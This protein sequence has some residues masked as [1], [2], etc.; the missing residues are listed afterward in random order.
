MQNA[1]KNMKDSL[2]RNPMTQVVVLI[3]IAI[4]AWWLSAHPLSSDES[5]TYHHR[6]WSSAYFIVSLLGGI[7][8]LI[9]S[10]YWGGRKSLLGRAL[11]AFSVGLLLQTFGQLAYN[12]YIIILKTEAPY[13][14]LGDVGYFGSVLAY[15]YGV[16]LLGHV[17]GIKFSFKS[18]RNQ[19][20]AVA[21][22]LLMLVSTWLI[23][24]KGYE[25]DWSN[26]MRI[27]LDFGYPLGQA[28]YVS[29]ALVVLLMTRKFLGG[30]MRKPLMLLVFA[31]FIQ[32]MSDFNFLYETIHGT[33]YA[34]S[35]GDY[36]YTASYLFMTLGLIY[37][38]T[39]FKKIRES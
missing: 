22:P 10:K 31:L 24:L 35:P 3:F 11:L 17:A 27:F 39:T 5:F 18:F 32:Y 25:F 8:G 9:I 13:P 37:V 38:G 15:I 14:S 36:L 16:Y 34:G 4:T 2:F 23:F 19:I 21:L 33:W 30:L 6:L 12:Y 20:V 1:F 7:F 28:I 26:P 29:M